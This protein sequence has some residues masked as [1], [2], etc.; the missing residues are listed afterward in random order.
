MSTY[1]ALRSHILFIALVVLMFSGVAE[2]STL[3][4]AGI[5][6]Q[7]RCGNT[8]VDVRAY[9][10]GLMYQ[11]AP[12]VPQ[13]DRVLEIRPQEGCAV[14][15]WT[16]PIVATAQ[17]IFAEVGAQPESVDATKPPFYWYP[18]GTLQNADAT[19]IHRVILSGLTPGKTYSYRLVSRSHPTAVPYISA[20][21]FLTVP[22]TPPI[23]SSIVPSP[24][25]SVSVPSGTSTPTVA[26]TATTTPPSVT[27]TTKTVTE[28]MTITIPT[29]AV[30]VTPE[31]AVLHETVSSTEES[32]PTPISAI[33]AFE[34][35]Q[36]I[37]SDAST[38]W[39]RFARAFS[40]GSSAPAVHNQAV[41]SAPVVVE[42]PV[43]EN[44]Q[45]LLVVHDTT[46]PASVSLPGSGLFVND[47]YIVPSLFF[48]V[49]LYLLQQLLLPALGM[50]VER[51]LVFWMF[52]IIAIAVFAA[53]LK[54][55]YVTIFMLALFLALLA[56]YILELFDQEEH[57]SHS[58]TQSA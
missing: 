13:N 54:L 19:G 48:L 18:T 17:I 2:A 34:S 56:W 52:G 22:I 39:A 43:V 21:K 40:F 55:F 50:K 35:A 1:T 44:S 31:T 30:A 33:A 29:P 42:A 25:P 37:V 23:V 41:V 47:K 46:A 3:P 11:P 15:E 5:V 24:V 38:F 4:A 9:G 16:T 51:P 20:E 14:V 36:D 45:N 32:T 57:P 7:Q 53:L 12:I 58:T 49:L 6:E 10:A 28:T 27:Y 8:T 26:V